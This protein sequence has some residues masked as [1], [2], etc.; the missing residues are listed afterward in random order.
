MRA[1]RSPAG[2]AL[3]LL[4]AGAAE[5]QPYVPTDC[6]A[7]FAG[8]PA[9]HF[10]D[11]AHAAWYRRF[12]SGSCAGVPG[13]CMSGQPDWNS[14]V[15]S[16]VARAAPERQAA[17]AAEACRLGRLIGLEWARDN[18]VRRI[19]THDLGEL[20]RLLNAAGAPEDRLAATE[21]RVRQLLR[22]APTA[23]SGAP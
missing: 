20:S 18:A 4:L 13:F 12:W 10:D 7:A 11:A 6:T 22:P 16:L 21:T 1:N 23:Q 2:L 8:A 5:A 15:R 19:S 14:Q 17:A 9:D 3:A